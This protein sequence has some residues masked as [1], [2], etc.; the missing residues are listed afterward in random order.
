MCV[1]VYVFVFVCVCV[2]VLICHGFSLSLFSLLCMSMYRSSPS[3][4]HI[5]P[6]NQQRYWLHWSTSFKSWII[7]SCE[8]FFFYFFSLCKC[9]IFN[10]LNKFFAFFFCF[11]NLQPHPLFPPSSHLGSDIVYMIPHVALTLTTVPKGGMAVYLGV[12]GGGESSS[13]TI[14]GSITSGDHPVLYRLLEGV[15]QV[16]IRCFNTSIRCFNTGIRCFNTSIRCF[17]T[18]LSF[19][20]A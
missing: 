15:P 10:F 18:R 16:R 8:N 12:G 9:Y 20:F 2:R 7:R 5:F 1:S 4:A 14:R 6:C 11:F 13:F 17:Y 19:I 3:Y